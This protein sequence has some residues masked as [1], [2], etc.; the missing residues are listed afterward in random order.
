MHRG[1]LRFEY[2]RKRDEVSGS[3]PLKQAHIELTRL[4]TPPCHN[5]DVH[6]IG[7]R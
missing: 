3:H 5:G 2:E 1:G 7:V 6:V 4:T